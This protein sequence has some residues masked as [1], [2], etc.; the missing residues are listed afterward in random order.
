LE[1]TDSQSKSIELIGNL[2]LDISSLDQLLLNGIELSI[3]LHRQAPSYV[4]NCS[5]AEA[6]KRFQIRMNQCKLYIKKVSPTASAHLALEAAVQNNPIESFF[7]RHTIKTFNVAVGEWSKVIENPFLGVCPNYL[8]V[9]MCRQNPLHG[10]Y[11][12]DPHNL[13]N[14]NLKRLNVTL[15]GNSVCDY[16][17]DFASKKF[18]IPYFFNFINYGL[19][20]SVNGLTYDEFNAHK[21]VYVFDLSPEDAASSQSGGSLS[22]DRRG[23][24]R[25]NF[26]FNEGVTEN[27]TI[28]LIGVSQ[29]ALTLTTDRRVI[30]HYI[31]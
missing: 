15:D 31:M 7:K 10:S 28:I 16:S 13:S 21:N 22:L 2:M 6:T 4:I 26:N 25:L 18:V 23:V 29:A 1:N 27:S 24:L 17:M 12:S 11:K 30:T 14:L 19:E 5:E 9:L 8:M 20:H 3:R